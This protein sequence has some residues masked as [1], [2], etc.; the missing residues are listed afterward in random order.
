MEAKEFWHLYNFENEYSCSWIA[1]PHSLLDSFSRSFCQDTWLLKMLVN[2]RLKT[3]SLNWFY[4]W[5]WQ[6][7]RVVK[8]KT[9]ILEKVCCALE[10]FTWSSMHP[11]CIIFVTSETSFQNSKF[12]DTDKFKSVGKNWKVENPVIAL[13]LTIRDG[14]VKVRAMIFL[15][16]MGCIKLFMTKF[17]QNHCFEKRCFLNWFLLIFF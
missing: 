4:L 8:A 15:V 5:L 17:W 1:P 14:D 11:F 6:M 3:I 2:F 16:N 10:N 12:G 7:W 9:N 13:S